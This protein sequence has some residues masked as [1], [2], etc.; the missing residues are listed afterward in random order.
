VT[1]WAVAVAIL[2][3]VLG[4]G[5]VYAARWGEADR[6]EAVTSVECDVVVWVWPRVECRHPQP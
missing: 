5:V 2:T 6:L 1:F 4:W 3:A